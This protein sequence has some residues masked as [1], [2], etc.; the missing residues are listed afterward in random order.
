MVVLKCNLFLIASFV[1]HTFSDAGNGLMLFLVSSD[2]FL[3]GTSADIY[4]LQNESLI[5]TKIMLKGKI[6]FIGRILQFLEVTKPK[7]E[8]AV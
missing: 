7:L 2:D 6:H 3:F 4:M 8:N 5:P 1:V